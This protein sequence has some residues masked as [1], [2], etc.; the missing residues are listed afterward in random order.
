MRIAKFFV[1]GSALAFMGILGASTA[2]SG[3]SYDCNK[4][5]KA[6]PNDPDPTQTQI[7]QCKKCQAEASALADCSKGKVTCTADGKTDPAGGL[8]LALACPQQIANYQQCIQK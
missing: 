7:D 5:T 6:C 3:S 4:P 2:C 8:A 1:F